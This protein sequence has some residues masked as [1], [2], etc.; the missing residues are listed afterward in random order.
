MGCGSDGDIE[1]FVKL[2]T[3]KGAAFEVGGDDCVAKAKSVGEWRKKNTKKYNEMRKSLAKDYK[4]GPPDKYKA[5][6][7]K[8]KKSV[9]GAMMKCSNDPIFGKMMDD[10]GSL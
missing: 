3:E 5:A 2:D 4:E 1:A 7:K 8:N 6:L 10:T 9:M